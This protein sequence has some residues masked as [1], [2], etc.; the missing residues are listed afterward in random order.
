MSSKILHLVNKY[1]DKLDKLEDS[2][3]NE[4]IKR[5][6]ELCKL[7]VLVLLKHCSD[8]EIL[9]YL[10]RPREQVNQILLDTERL[11]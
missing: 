10:L 2:N 1:N 8:E 6:V 11:D 5:L 4:E 3:N 9:T 7:E